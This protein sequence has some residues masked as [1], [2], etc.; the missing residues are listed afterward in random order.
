VYDTI[1]KAPER[2]D[3]QS[4]PCG[5]PQKTDETT[6]KLLAERA[7]LV[8]TQPLNELHQSVAPNICLR[9]IQRRLREKEIKKYCLQKK[10]PLSVRHRSQRFTWALEHKHWTEEWKIVIWSDE[11]SIQLGS[12]QGRP[13][14]FRLQGNKCLDIDA[15]E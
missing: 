4:L 5:H 7:M 6:D 10:L 12:G 3:N 15:A 13:Y 9:T 1:Q 8:P 14:V 2:V 11:C